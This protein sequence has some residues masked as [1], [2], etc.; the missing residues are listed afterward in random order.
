MKLNKILALIVAGITV[1]ISVQAG[2]ILPGDVPNNV[3]SIFTTADTLV[4]LRGYTDS[5][6]TMPGNFYSAGAGNWFGTGS[7]QS[8]DGTET[9]TMQ[10]APGVGLSGFGDIYTR[11]VITISGFLSDPRLNVG[12]NPGVLA[13]SYSSGT[14]TLNLD[15]NGGGFR[16]FTLA[17]QSASAGQLLTVSLDYAT[18]PQW[19][20]ANIDYAAVPVPEPTTI[21]VGLVGLATLGLVR[22]FRR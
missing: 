8:L 6:S 9:M 2:T 22:R 19:A 18:A 5:A 4:T 20:I 7:N 16:N 14:L 11:A 17:D 13:N 1:G 10:F 15:W 21:A 3:S 12:S